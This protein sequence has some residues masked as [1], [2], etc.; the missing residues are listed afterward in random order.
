MVVE[1]IVVCY[2][3]ENVFVFSVY[4]GIYYMFELLSVLV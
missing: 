1:V 4:F 3:C 2:G